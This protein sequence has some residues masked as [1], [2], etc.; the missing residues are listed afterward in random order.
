[1]SDVA[2]ALA[3]V[4]FTTTPALI[5]KLYKLK[6]LSARDARDVFDQALFAL[7]QLRAKAGPSSQAFDGARELLETAIAQIAVE[8][9]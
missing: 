9:P 7:E 6:V 4:G 2:H 8:G 3:L 5:T 1:M